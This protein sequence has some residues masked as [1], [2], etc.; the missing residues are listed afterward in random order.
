MRKIQFLA[1]TLGFSSWP[2]TVRAATIFAPHPGDDDE[3]V[4]GKNESA[5]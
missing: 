1:E 5:D 2:C 3:A 4:V